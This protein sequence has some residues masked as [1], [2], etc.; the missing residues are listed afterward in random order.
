MTSERKQLIF[1]V[2]PGVLFVLAGLRDFFLPGFLCISSH[3]SDGR[4]NLVVG[5]AFVALALWRWKHPTRSQA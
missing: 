3:P 1:T 5:V 2:L 4:V